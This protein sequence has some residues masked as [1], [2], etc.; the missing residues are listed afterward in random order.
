MKRHTIHL[1][2]PRAKGARLS[3]GALRELLDTLLASAR[4]AVRLRVDGRGLTGQPPVWI[5]RISEVDVLPLEAGSTNVIV[6]APTL[7]EAAPDRFLQADFL[8]DIDAQ[9]TCIDVME[10]SLA[11]ALAED[12]ASE[13]YDAG[14]LKTFSGFSRLWRH[15]IECLELDGG[16]R[17]VR[18]DAAA[19]ARIEKLQREIPADQQVVVVGKLDQLHHSRRMF[20]LRTDDGKDVRGLAGD[21]VRLE[22]LGALFGHR[23]S[24]RR[25]PL[26]R[27]GRDP[28]GRGASHRAGRLRSGGFLSRAETVAPARGEPFLRQGSG[29]EVGYRGHL[30]QVAGG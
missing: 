9:A 21:S 28:H 19:T 13:R 27:L 20:T 10:E 15:G 1:T 11:D 25:R 22:D 30:R 26:S 5:E 12:S 18:L 23:A 16:N 14:L 24:V 6:E 29:A 3:A 7:S 8:L 17:P 4:H 2:G